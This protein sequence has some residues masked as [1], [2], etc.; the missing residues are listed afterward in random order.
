MTDVGGDTDDEEGFSDYDSDEE[1]ADTADLYDEDDN[2]VDH[3]VARIRTTIRLLAV[4]D[5]IIVM[6]LV[7][8]CIAKFFPT[9]TLTEPALWAYAFH[10]FVWIFVVIVSGNGNEA[11][12]K[13]YVTWQVY[14]ERHSKADKNLK[15]K[16]SLQGGYLR[17][18]KWNY[19]WWATTFSLVLIM[20]ACD[21][22]IL[23]WRIILVWNCWSG[24][25][26]TSCRNALLRGYVQIAIQIIYVFI[27]NLF[28]F[29]SLSKLGMYYRGWSVFK[30][31]ED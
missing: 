27:I 31:K 1:I 15:W 4:V 12:R 9:S 2:S 21:I 20:A 17:R 28:Y 16:A 30:Q 29:I 18:A 8:L 6:I 3:Y 13:L 14:I 11:D 10:F 19:D 7:I 24:N 26:P 22:A 5:A 23:I 25:A